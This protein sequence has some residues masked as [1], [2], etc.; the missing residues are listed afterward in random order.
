MKVGI[1]SGN[2]RILRMM[3]KGIMVNGIK[4]SIRQ[5]KRANIPITAYV[6]IGLPTETKD[7]MLDTLRLCKELD[8][9]WVSLSVATPWYGTDMY[10][11]VTQ[12]LGVVIN[13][14][15]LFH[16]SA[17]SFNKNV[18]P[19]LVSKFMDLNDGKHREK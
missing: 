1:E 17:S 11:Y 18:T 3:R 14:D 8:P 9:N 19:D 2:N 12:T 7:E 10:N 6:M 5:I 15:L 13:D 16:Q 4:R